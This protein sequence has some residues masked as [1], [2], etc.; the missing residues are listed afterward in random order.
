MIYAFAMYHL[1]LI[2]LATD[3]HMTF[4][5]APE[6]NKKL[7][8]LKLNI[9]NVNKN[10]GHS[11]FSSIMSALSIDV[12]ASRDLLDPFSEEVALPVE[13]CPSAHRRMSHLLVIFVSSNREM[14]DPLQ[15]YNP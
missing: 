2:F 11:V 9:S 8:T 12:R 5:D 15:C 6:S 13:V 7:C 1:A 4:T 10:S 3:S 14:F